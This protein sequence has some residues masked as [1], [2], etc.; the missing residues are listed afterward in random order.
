MALPFEPGGFG[1]QADY[2]FVSAMDL[3]KPQ[4]DNELGRRYGN[5]Y[6]S[7]FLMNINYAKPVMGYEYFHFEE[8]RIYPKLNASNSGAGSAGAAVT[9][10][11]A[12]NA[13]D[14]YSL[15]EPPFV[16]SVDK[17]IVVARVGDIISIKPA[18]GVVNSSSMILARVQS[19]N[20]S[21]GTFSAIPLETGVAIP[22]I[23]VAT[24]IA[25]VGNAFGEGDIQP[26]SRASKVS[27]YSNNV[28][29]FKDTFELPG[30]AK[31]LQT[32]VEF[33]GTNGQKGKYYVLK[34]EEDAY[35]RFLNTRELGLLTNKKIT[36]ATLANAQA[37]A[38]P[39]TPT[40][41]TEGLIPFIQSQGNN[42]G[43]S[44]LTGFSKADMD[45]IVVTLDSQKGA[46]ENLFMCGI[47]LSLAIDEVL[48]DSRQNG[49]VTFGAY[50]FGT[51]ASINY[52]FDS[53]K[54]GN[55]VFKKKTMDSFNDLQ[56]LGAQGYG[57]PY[58]GMIIPMDAKMDSKT[59]EKM[60]SLRVRYLVDENGARQ[61]KRAYVEGFSQFQDGKDIVSMRYS[62][63]VGFQGIGGN[64]FF[65]IERV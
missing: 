44:A 24:E 36:N 43:Y 45:E 20:K 15:H 22:S 26:E 6:L 33:T 9:F 31:G 12:S 25:I 27:K 55:Y 42:L 62:D 38:T 5:Q 49:A 28:Q 50:S 51:D 23:P 40:L 30:T 39:G 56:S 63:A 41:T 13:R 52:Q 14:A 8:G 46:K 53:Y 54:I 3:H 4:F 7:E 29:F 18:S 34:G 21:A 64:R 65:Y 59:G 60:S 37:S 57:Y 19:V 48:A 58:E 16:G 11:L 10:Q 1:T 32:W 47:Q 35:V 61:N 17:D 2:G